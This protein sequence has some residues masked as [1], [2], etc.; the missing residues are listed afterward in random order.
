[1]EFKKKFL[2][3]FVVLII[4]VGAMINFRYQTA[5]AKGGVWKCAYCDM[6]TTGHDYPNSGSCYRN[7]G[8]PHSWYLYRRI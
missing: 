6:E 3:I 1:M 7:N 8:G 2:M 4:T 5:Y